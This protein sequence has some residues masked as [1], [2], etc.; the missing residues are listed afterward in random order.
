MTD[1]PD[2]EKQY[3]TVNL[4]E[5]D[6]QQ[7]PPGLRCP[8]CE[9]EHDEITAIYQRAWTHHAPQ[10]HVGWVLM[11]G[12]LLSATEWT[13]VSRPNTNECGSGYTARWERR[14]PAPIAD[15]RDEEG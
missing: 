9:T 1:R 2:T 10:R 14:T 11:C 13:W 6:P 15:R 4:F 8:T 7:V 3:P 5:L 12:C